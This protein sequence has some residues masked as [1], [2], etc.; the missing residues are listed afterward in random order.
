MIPDSSAP[1]FPFGWSKDSFPADF[2]AASV[3]SV[4]SRLP[5][6]LSLTTPAMIV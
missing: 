3:Q 4:W 6:I 2:H 5:L 1:S